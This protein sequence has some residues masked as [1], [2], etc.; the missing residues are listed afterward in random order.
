MA[1]LVESRKLEAKPSGEPGWSWRKALIY[2][3]VVASFYLIFV[4]INGP[5]TRVNETIAW[6]LIVN[7][8]SSVFFMTGFATAQDIVAIFATRSGL[9][10]AERQPYY[11]STTQ[12]TAQVDPGTPIMTTTVT[13]APTAP[14]N[15]DVPLDEPS[16]GARP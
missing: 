8:I 16:P 12:T 7:I 2:P 15:G 11:Q 13:T 14:V 9:P 5:D 10:Y 6:G 4:M 1:Q 3:N